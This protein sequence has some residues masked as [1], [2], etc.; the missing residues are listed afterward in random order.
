MKE[1]A[2]E[3]ILHKLNVSNPKTIYCRLDKFSKLLNNFSYDNYKKNLEKYK[4]YEF[5]SNNSNKNIP[6]PIDVKKY[7]DSPKNSEEKIKTISILYKKIIYNFDVYHDF[8][9]A[10]IP[11][12]FLN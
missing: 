10:H 11:K 8:E 5:G 7:M 12:L 6:E 1:F 4:I 9:S 2:I 3:Y